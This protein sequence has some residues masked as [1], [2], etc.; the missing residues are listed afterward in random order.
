MPA[1]AAAAAAPQAGSGSAALMA[2][3]SVQ[4]YAQPEALTETGSGSPHS[5]QY[6]NTWSHTVIGLQVFDRLD[7]LWRPKH[8][9]T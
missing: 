9:V 8:G 4:G 7:Q 5:K 6:C 3:V 1:P 2:R